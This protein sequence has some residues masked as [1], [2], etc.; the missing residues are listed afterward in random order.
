MQMLLLVVLLFQGIPQ[1]VQT[2]SVE[3]IVVKIGTGE[4]VF[5]AQVVL[6][7]VEGPIRG[8]L[9]ATTDGSGK[10]AVSNIPPGRYRIFASRDGYVRAEY[11]QRT[12]GGSGKVLTFVAGQQLKDVLLPLTATSTI[13]GRVF[14]RYGEPVV[15]TNV[16]AL[17]YRYA[18]GQRVLATVQSA[19]TNDLGEYRLYWLQPGKYIVSATPPLGP[20]V[21][22]NFIM[23]ENGAAVSVIASPVDVIRLNGNAAASLGIVPSNEVGL[24]VYYPGATDAGSAAPVDLKPGVHFAGVDFTIVPVRAVNVRGR[25]ISSTTGQRPRGGSVML[26]SHGTGG[27]VSQRNATISASTGDFEFEGVA[28]GSYEIVSTSNDPTIPGLAG[29]L[30]AR[31]TVE[32]G[33]VDL[34]N[35][36]VILQ[37]GFKVAGRLLIEGQPAKTTQ[38]SPV[39][40][41]NLRLDPP[42]NGPGFP[43]TA[44]TVNS[45]DGSFT[46]TGVSSG[47]Y[48]VAVTNLPKNAYVKSA[49][50]GGTEVLNAGVRI[51]GEP[52]GALEIQIGQNPGTFD[53]AVIDDNQ[54]AASGATVVLVPDPSRRQRQDAYRSA[55][56]NES[57]RVHFEGVIPGDYKVF[58]WDE[59]EFSAWQDPDFIR[60]Y[61]DRGK[62]LRILENG[63][64]SGE[65]RLI[66]Q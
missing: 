45:T 21:D 8:T 1:T 54:E 59:V 18:N 25:V 51:D 35:V 32:V 56:T 53:A 62:P 48:R 14:D 46:V 23:L 60:M 42:V 50:L 39:I 31:I 65:L 49:L 3:G 11:G 55:T 38:G 26:V 4:P 19:R 66:K 33:N 58:A 2:A 64:A 6:S 63:T 7:V 61:E 27:T 44:G 36:S 57:G 43:P 13:S 29:R 10:F 5:R 15:N 17:K 24:T 12:P 22:G 20:R 9:A 16:Q 41:V 28:P 40:Q 47:T 30:S 52:G 37:P 34:D